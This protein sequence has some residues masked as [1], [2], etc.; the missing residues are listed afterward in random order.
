MKNTSKKMISFLLAVIM[1]FT[2][3]SVGLTAFA[4]DSRSLAYSDKAEKD[5]ENASEVFDYCVRII[6]NSSVSTGQPLYK[7]LGVS[8]YATAQEVIGA[9][10][11]MI[12]KV[13]NGGSKSSTDLKTFITSHSSVTAIDESNWKDGYAKYFDYLT[14][15]NPQAD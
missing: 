15:P 4:S 13:L 8:P 11:P 12:L 7:E 6:L 10:S 9:A 2:S 5:Y 1:A 14:D 3:C